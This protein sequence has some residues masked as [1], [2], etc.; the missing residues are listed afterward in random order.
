MSFSGIRVMVRELN[1]SNNSLIYARLDK[2]KPFNFPNLIIASW[3]SSIYT[4]SIYLNI[5][6]SWMLYSKPLNSTDE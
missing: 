5:E 3:G 1:I 4:G 6:R 2:Q